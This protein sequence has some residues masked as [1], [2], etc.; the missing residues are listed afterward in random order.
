MRKTRNNI[1]GVNAFH[2]TIQNRLKGTPRTWGSRRSQSA[3]EKHIPKKGTL[4]KS[5]DQMD[6]FL[7]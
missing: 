7:T 6:G 5:I 3:T 1:A 4:A 2:P